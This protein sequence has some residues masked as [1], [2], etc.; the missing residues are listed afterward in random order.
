MCGYYSD[1]KHW[2]NKILKN[3][4]ELWIGPYKWLQLFY[5]I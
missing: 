5:D 1:K 3:A 2:Y 4:V